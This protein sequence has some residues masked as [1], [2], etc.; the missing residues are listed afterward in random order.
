MR[1]SR[2]A[3][4]PRLRPGRARQHRRRAGLERRARSAARARHRQRVRL[5][6]GRARRQPGRA[7]D[8][9]R[10]RRGRRRGR[11]PGPGRAPCCSRRGSRRRRIASSWPASHIAEATELA[12]AIDDVDLQARCCYYLAYVVSHDGEFRQAMELT[13]RSRRALRR[14]GPAVGP[15]RELAL[16]RPGRDLRRRR[17]SAASRRAIRS[18]H[19][20]RPVDDP[21]LHVRGDAMLGELAR[22]QHRFDDAVVHLG[23]AAET[24]RRLGFLQTEAYQLVEPRTGA[25]PGRRLRRPARPPCELAVDK[26]EATGDVRLA[27]LARVHLGR[28]L[29]ALGQTAA[30]AG[31]ARGGDARGTARPAAGSRPRSVSACSP[32]WT[33]RTACP[34]PRTGSQPILDEARARDDAPVEVL[35]PRRARST[36]RGEAA[37]ARARGLLRGGR[38]ADGPPPRTSSPTATGPTPAQSGG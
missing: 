21:W 14:A 28:V 4:L 16:R 35:R 1:S 24:S 27:A 13:D 31:G 11:R 18:Q 29:R 6:L 32:R 30:G 8:P 2:Q 3:E 12:D 38:R 19:W 36:R 15:G 26:A 37:T 22:I 17:A 33:P 9:G 5:G 25:V 34:A 10:A 20:L 23:R 7:T